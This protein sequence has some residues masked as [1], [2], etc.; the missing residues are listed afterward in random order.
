MPEGA[1][2][3]WEVAEV[4][5]GLGGRCCTSRAPIENAL[6]LQIPAA[7]F[8]PHE[9]SQQPVLE[10]EPSPLKSTYPQA[11]YLAGAIQGDTVLA[12]AW[13]RKLEPSTW[14][15][16]LHGVGWLYL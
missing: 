4:T 13:E 2:P 5:R 10:E 12:Q 9:P 16:S 6:D 8:I 14:R 11:R 7:V 15:R 3:A 1:L